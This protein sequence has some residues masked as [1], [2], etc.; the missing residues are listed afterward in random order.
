MVVFYGKEKEVERRW[1][2][3]NFNV[4]FSDLI[5]VDRVIEDIRFVG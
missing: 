3:G 1:K 4:Y 5:L 2:E